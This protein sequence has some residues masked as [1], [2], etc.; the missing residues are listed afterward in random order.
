MKNEPRLLTFLQK[1][2]SD[3]PRPIFEKLGYDP[4]ENEIP[5]PVD[6]VNGEN[7]LVIGTCLGGP[8]NIEYLYCTKTGNFLVREY[9]WDE[10]GV[11][12]ARYEKF[13]LAK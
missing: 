8:E 4:F 5:P 6:K 3:D 7:F 10:N 13:E 11:V 2:K 9:F 12:T 1:W